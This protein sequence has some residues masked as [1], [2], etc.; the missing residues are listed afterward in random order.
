MEVSSLYLGLGSSFT[1]SIAALVSQLSFGVF[2]CLLSRA[3]TS[4]FHPLTVAL[5]IC[6]LLAMLGAKYNHQLPTSVF[7]DSFSIILQLMGIQFVWF[8]LAVISQD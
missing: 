8:N 6:V 4:P 7:K 3:I 5:V 1:V 2:H